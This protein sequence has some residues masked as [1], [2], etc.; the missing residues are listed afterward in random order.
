M[1]DGSRDHLCAHFHLDTPCTMLTTLG[2]KYL[3]FPELTSCC[4]CCSYKTG[5][6]PLG[7]SWL[8]NATGNLKYRGVETV[9]GRACNHWTVQGLFVEPQFLNHYWQFTDT[10]LPCQIDSYNYLFNMSQR[11]D[12]WYTFDYASVDVSEQDPSLF[13]PPPY[14]ENAALCRGGVCDDSE[15]PP[16]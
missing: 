15:D 10:G 6:G 2:W 12:N 14:C 8:S 7:T 13:A 16:S 1:A 4:R 11:A 5:C 9:E 3:V